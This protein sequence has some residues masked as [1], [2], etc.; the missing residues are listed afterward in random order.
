MQR[1]N[2]LVWRGVLLG[3]AGLLCIINPSLSVTTVISILG[4]MALVIGSFT[5]L[6]EYRRKQATDTYSY[7]V[8]EGLFNVIVGI[9]IIANPSGTAALLLTLLGVLL[10]LM[11]LLQWYGSM[12]QPKGHPAKA[13]MLAGG[14]LTAVLGALIIANP[15]GS[16]A[17]LVTLIGMGLLISGG[18]TIWL[19]LRLAD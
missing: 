2:G 1:S 11:G 15:F 12:Q 19:G 3:L 7:R 16:A 6:T 13:L 14:I 17:V 18:V 4:V 8:F 10:L 5:L 9:V